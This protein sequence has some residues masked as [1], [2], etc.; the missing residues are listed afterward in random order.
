MAQSRALFCILL[1]IILCQHA[2]AL[3]NDSEQP[4]KIVADSSLF[5]YKTGIDTYEG[6]VKIDQGTSHL[7]ADRLITK[8]NKQHKMIEAIATGIKKLAEY[9][10]IPKTGD[11]PLNAKAKIIKFYPLTST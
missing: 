10:T 6:N 4:M 2:L 7:I 9:S 5:N 11:A 1:F 8:K 3:P